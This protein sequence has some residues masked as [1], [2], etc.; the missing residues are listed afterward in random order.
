MSTGLGVRPR[1]LVSV[2]VGDALRF[3]EELGPPV[4]LVEV[5][6]AYLVVAVDLPLAGGFLS[7]DGSLP[8]VGPLAEVVDDLGAEGETR[9]GE[10]RLGAALELRLAPAA[11][12]GTAGSGSLGFLAFLVPLR[13]GGTV[14]PESELSLRFPLTLALALGAVGAG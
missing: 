9:A 3:R 14:G 10:V 2:S 1:F 6:G 8:R 12:E 4:V 7:T 5:A 11:L 13:S